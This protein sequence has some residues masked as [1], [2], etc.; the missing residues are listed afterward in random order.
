M[1]FVNSNNLVA[2]LFTSVYYPWHVT[3]FAVR[4]FVMVCLHGWVS[5]VQSRIVDSRLA[6][7]RLIHLWCCQASLFLVVHVLQCLPYSLSLYSLQCCRGFLY[8]SGDLCFASHMPF[9]SLNVSVE[10][11]LFCLTQFFCNISLAV[12][13]VVSSNCCRNSSGVWLANYL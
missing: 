8:S 9:V 5:A 12:A 11:Q 3:S 10:V 7:D 2:I 1:L 6:P 4:R 13:S